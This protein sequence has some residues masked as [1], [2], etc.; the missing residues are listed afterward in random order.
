MKEKVGDDQFF[1]GN[2]YKNCPA[3]TRKGA[4]FKILEHKTYMGI[5]P[6]QK[7]RLIEEYKSLECSSKQR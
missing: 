5:E 2:C 3:E 1:C 4:N 6:I 7:K